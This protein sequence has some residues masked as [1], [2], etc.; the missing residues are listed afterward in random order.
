MDLLSKIQIDF[1]VS[2][3]V[4]ESPPKSKLIKYLVN[5]LDSKHKTLASVADKLS[6]HA[7]D[8]AIFLLNYFQPKYERVVDEGLEEVKKQ[9]YEVKSN[10][11]ETFIGLRKK[12]MPWLYIIRGYEIMSDRGHVILGGIPDKFPFE[13]AHYTHGPKLEDVLKWGKDKDALIIP[14]HPLHDSPFE[15]ALLKGLALIGK[16]DPSGIN[17]GLSEDDL[18]DLKDYFDAIEYASLSVSEN[19]SKKIRNLAGILHK[20]ALANSDGTIESAFSEY[21]HI[22]KYDFSTP[23]MMRKTIRTALNSRNNFRPVIRNNRERHSEKAK[24]FLLN[25]LQTRDNF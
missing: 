19:Q 13:E 8:R 11:K 18:Y 22:H 7:S 20:P 6:Y 3:W 5:H 17:L 16:R 15:K 21:N 1:H 2:G 12:N 4:S 9:G 23:E 14:S 10:H 24:H 25:L